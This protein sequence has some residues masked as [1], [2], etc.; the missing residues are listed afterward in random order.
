VNDQTIRERYVELLLDRVRRDPYPSTQYMDLLE[1]SL[2][3]PEQ[4]IEYL[5]ALLD[6]VEA[7]PFPSLPM[8]RRIHRIVAALP[9]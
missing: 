2:S 9:R 8:L 1:A 3:R 6:K 5:E 7:T 4:L